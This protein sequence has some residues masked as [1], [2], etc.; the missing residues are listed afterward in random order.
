MKLSAFIVVGTAVTC[1]LLGPALAQAPPMPTPSGSES[2]MM[3]H[4][5]MD[6]QV[7]SID[8]KKGWVHVKTAEGVLTLHFPPPALQNVKKGDKITVELSMKDN[9]PAGKK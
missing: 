3:G 4:H 9:G 1:L 8:A 6:G 5:T 2:G 7:T